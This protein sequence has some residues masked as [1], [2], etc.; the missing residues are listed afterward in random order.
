M[1]FRYVTTRLL[2]ADIATSVRLYEEV[3]GLTPAMNGEGYAYFEV[4]TNIGLE[5][6]ERKFIA[7]LVN[8]GARPNP[9]A[10]QDRFLLDFEVES[11]D[12]VCDDLWE[13]GIEVVAEPTD[14]PDWGNV[15]TAHFRAPD[16]NFIEIYHRLAAEV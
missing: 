14:H 3:L 2:V 11:V 16:D 4:G 6:M 7:D 9:A 8:A 13:K 15:R 10:V 5:M 1:A 12:V